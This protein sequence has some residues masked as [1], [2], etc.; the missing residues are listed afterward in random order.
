[1]KNKTTKDLSPYGAEFFKVFLRSKGKYETPEVN[2]F[3]RPY[4]AKEDT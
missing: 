4:D 3:V 2:I 1:M